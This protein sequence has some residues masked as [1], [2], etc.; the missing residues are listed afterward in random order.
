VDNQTLK[1]LI[2]KVGGLMLYKISGVCR[3][4]FDSIILSSFL[5][6]AI[7][8]KYQNYYYIMN[9][10]GSI[11]AIIT[12]AATASIGN[13]IATETVEKNLD[14]FK[15]FSLL[16]NW[17]AGWC[18]VCLL[19]LYQ[20]FM[21]IWLGKEFLFSFDIVIL[22]CLYFYSCKVS[23]ILF[24]YRQA[25]GLWWEDKLRPIIESI[26][27]LILNI[28]VVK[29]FGVCGVIVSTI[30]TIV[31][32]NIPWGSFIL[33][34]HYFKG[35]M[36]EYL[37]DTTFNCVIVIIASVVTF[38]IC[39]MF[40]SDGIILLLERFVLC[41]IIPN[42]LFYLAYFKSSYFNKSVNLIKRIIKK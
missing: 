15:T 7:L 10:V 38:A 30:V 12:T 32:I 21:K 18:S 41:L 34:K 1:E 35:G 14:N 23:D 25:A 16:Y 40:K 28:I 5:G 9:A 42:I 4:A 29:Y 8:A 19:C 3:N 13:S 26:A 2:K 20:P 36:K 31:F 24:T 33:F 37:K 17:I 22:L 27:N 6:L 11:I 39:K